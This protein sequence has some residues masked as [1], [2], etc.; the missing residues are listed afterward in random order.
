MSQGSKGETR[1]GAIQAIQVDADKGVITSYGQRFLFIPVELI[2]SIEDRLVDMVGPVTATSFQ[3]E[4]GKQGGRHY[5]QMAQKS[6]YNIKSPADVSMIAAN[7]GT[8]GGWGK[9]SVE[10]LDFKQKKLRVKWTNGVS[11]RPGKKGKT[12]VCHFGRGVLTGA[13]EAMFGRKLE[14]IEITCQGKGDAYCEAIIAPPEL[15]GRIAE[16]GK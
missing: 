2:H 15:V 16:T 9:L 7:L 14:S 13:A 12:P 8:L 11:V 1:K 10:D 5:I 6:G 3:Y 4:I